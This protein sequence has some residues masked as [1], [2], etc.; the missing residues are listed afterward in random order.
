MPAHESPE[1][2]EARGSLERVSL[3]QVER[4]RGLVPKLADT[5]ELTESLRERKKLETRK[6]LSWAAIGLALQRGGLEHVRTEEIAEAAGVSPRTFNNYFRSREEAI[7]A[8]AGDRAR[9]VALAFAD[10]PA[11]EPFGEALADVVVAEYTAGHEPLKAAVFQLRALMTTDCGVRP[12]ML[13]A[14]TKLEDELAPV[15][16]ERLGLPGDDLFPRVVAAAVN[17]AIRVATEYWLREDVDA[18]Y[19][20]LLRE[21][22]LTA[23]GLAEQ[24]PP[25]SPPGASLPENTNL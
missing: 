3:E 15:I 6:N 18:P 13:N 9:R 8:V 14:M 5:P 10:R 25:L 1:H 12:F 2:A 20:A 23:A 7:G 17:G 4:L 16:A 11:E 22:V 24:P 21:A 19:T